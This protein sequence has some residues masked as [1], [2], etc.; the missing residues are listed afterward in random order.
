MTTT[1]A[2]L[3]AAIETEF[4]RNRQLH[5][6]RIQC[7]AGCSD[8]CHQLFQIT[9]PEAAKVSAGVQRLPA[10]VREPL[11]ERAALYV[12]ARARLR[13]ADGQ[14]ESWGRMPPPGT[15]LAC[16]ALWDGVCQIYDHRPFICRKFGMPIYNPDK[17][18]ILACE[19]N[20]RNGEEI[21][22]GELIQ[23][24]T[25]LHE[26]SKDF[27]R[28]YNNRGGYRDPD[29]ITVARAIVEDFTHCQSSEDR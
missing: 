9:E 14:R 6:P 27:Q 15:R 1:Y 17:G 26:R 10:A 25:G 18:Q 29:P 3:C 23:I 12:Q 22:D 24:Q 28:D 11:L 4:E 21:D 13:T 16:P 7:R 19:L 8:C 20:F 2:A 5:G